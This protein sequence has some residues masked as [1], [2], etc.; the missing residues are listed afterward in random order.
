[1]SAVFAW[2]AL[3]AW[4]SQSP[5]SGPPQGAPPPAGEPQAVVPPN[6]PP[7]GRTLVLGPFRGAAD[8]DSL[9]LWARASAPGVYR[10]EA[11]TGDGA[12]EVLST[13]AA[14]AEGGLALHWRVEGLRQHSFRGCWIV[15][16]DVE[17]WRDDAFVLAAA[18]GGDAAGARVVLG[19]CA[20]EKKH[21]DQ[22]VWSAI[23]ASHPDALLLLGDVPYIDS[24]ELEVQR[25]RYGEL[26]SL[27]PVR[28]CLSAVSTYAVWDDHDY[29]A[30]DTVGDVPGRELVRR[31]FLENHAQAPCGTGTGG[32]YTRCR[33]GPIEVFLL[34]TR[35]FANTETSP[36]AAPHPTLLGKA[37]V[38]WL[39]QGL[40]S[41]TAPFKVLA[42]GMP[43]N[44]ELRERKDDSWAEWSFERDAL[45][46]WLGE[47]RIG[48]VVLVGGDLHLMRMV[49]QP[50]AALC[51][52]DLP[53]CVAS[54][55][56]Q[57]P[58]RRRWV[59]L[60]GRLYEASV[61]STFLMLAAE[62]GAA[63]P[64]LTAQFCGNDG[65]ELFAQEFTAAELQPHEP[66]EPR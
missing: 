62:I 19:S 43:W 46:R 48:G 33:R 14:T 6:V 50:T 11:R 1:M 51:G 54:P 59:P 20:N 34:D 36:L 53:E 29:I 18:I 7:T 22:S 66:H 21:P 28:T 8:D 42:S 4:L 58:K 49:R 12:P 23:A 25:Q 65:R 31:A 24:K 15:G 32:V 10:L 35:W 61:S 60:E 39:Q 55:L 30:N 5:E 63:G 9:L 2:I 52:Y 40:R 17:V 27:E 13:D 26:F 37:Q 56:A 16:E 45:L 41:S 3:V 64:R 57:L 38:E 44:C 47:Q